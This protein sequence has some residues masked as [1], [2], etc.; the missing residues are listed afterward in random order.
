M[1]LEAVLEHLRSEK[2]VA[3]TCQA[4]G[5]SQSTF[6]TWKEQVL[7]GALDYLTHGGM[8]AGERQTREQIRQLEKALA[9]E[10]LHK[11]IAQEALELLKDPSWRKRVGSSDCPVDPEMSYVQSPL[12]RDRRQVEFEL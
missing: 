5:I 6:F 12:D 7:A 11:Q 9:R 4:R 8:S 1:E 2:S 10:T 3:E